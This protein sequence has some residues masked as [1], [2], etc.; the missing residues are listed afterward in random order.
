LA[1]S[2]QLPRRQVAD[3][4]I[5]LLRKEN[6][7]IRDLDKEIVIQALLRCRSSGRVSL[8]DALLWAIASQVDSGCGYNFDRRF[9][10]AGLEVR[11]RP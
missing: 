9:L 7:R 1:S 11:S 4:L 3:G 10:A 8:A 2:F 5:D 6:V